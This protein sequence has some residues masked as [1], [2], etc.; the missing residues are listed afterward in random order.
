M[1]CVSN[2]VLLQFTLYTVRESVYTSVLLIEAG[3]VN[4]SEEWL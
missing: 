4:H 2:D 1:G 3:C